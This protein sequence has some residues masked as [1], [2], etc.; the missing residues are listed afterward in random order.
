MSEIGRAFCTPDIKHIDKAHRE[1]TH[2][3]S[4]SSID[5]AG[6]IVEPSGANVANFMRNPVVLADHFYSIENIIG[7]ATSVTIDK[8]GLTATTQ[9]HKKGL[10]AEAFDLVEAGFAR[11]W[12]IGFRPTEQESLKDEKGNF[13]GFRFTEWELLEYSL[14]AI[15][16]NPDAVSNAIQRG[17]VSEQN[18][19]YF[20]MLNPSVP[21]G[22][23]PPAREA[24][25]AHKHSDERI[26][27]ISDWAKRGKYVQRGHIYKARKG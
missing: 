26:T 3:I 10:G 7:R 25:A 8:D 14:V 12:S 9:F 16:A 17:I 13:K 23:K 18:I 2:L 21:S 22:D 11:A 1:V 6:D 27:A 15:P 24:T 4:T 20:F 5:R 19:K